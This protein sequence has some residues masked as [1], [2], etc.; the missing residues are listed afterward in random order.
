MRWSLLGFV[1]LLGCGSHKLAQDDAGD[2]DA[3]VEPDGFDFGGDGGVEGGTCGAD[4]GASCSGDLHSVLDCNGNVVQTC[5]GD[6]GCAGGTCV[7]AC[8]A[9]KANRTSVGCEYYTFRTN[10]SGCFAVFVANTWNSAVTISADFNGQN[11]TV[12]TFARIP[13][14]NGASITYQTLPGGKLPPD[15][16]AILFIQNNGGQIPCPAPSADQQA[17]LAGLSPGGTSYG[18][19]IHITTDAPVVAYDID[20]YGGGGSFVTGSSLLL[21]TSVW[22]TNY[23]GVTSW[24]L[25]SNSTNPKLAFIGTVNGTMVK[26]SPSVAIVGGSGIAATGKGQ[27]QTYM[28][29]KGQIL[30]FEQAE[31]LV[32]SAIQADKPIGMFGGQGCFNIDACCCDSVHQQTP[33]VKALGSEYVGVR[34]RSRIDMQDEPSAWRIVGAVKGTQLTWDP[35]VPM[36]APT[37]LDL[38][39]EARFETPGPFVVRSQ[40]AQH[41]FYLAQYMTGGGGYMNRGDPEMVSVIPPAQYLNYYVFFTDPTYPETDLVFVRAKAADNTFKDVNLDCAGTLT[42]WQPVGKGGQYQ[43]ARADL[44][45]HNFQKQGSCD[46]GRHTVKSDG[47]FGLSIWGWGT[48]ET[49]PAFTSTY[50]SYGYPAG[51][52]AR[53]INMVVVP[54]DPH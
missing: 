48:D 9:A 29:D 10:Y 36:G 35:S 4:A 3:T 43:Y 14:G 32:G 45:R 38:G 41:P 53:S 19:A 16:V 51:A 25:A 5:P 30:H 34:Y 26:I 42:G 7:P 1:L 13:K 37:T 6:Q 17:G 20:P 50:T 40:D 12:P 39:T 22:D 8:D 52:S 33:P 18:R 28:V 15:E 24:P 21:P 23:V 27:P 11:L 31:D 47:P 2:M 46:N 54:P 49:S 44:V